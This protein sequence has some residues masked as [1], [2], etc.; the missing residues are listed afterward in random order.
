VY[1][2][3][4]KAFDRVR[5]CLLLNK[6]SANIEPARCLWLRSDFSGRTQRIRIG[7]CVSRDILATSGVPHGNH[8]GPLCF[9]WFVNELTGII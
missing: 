2:D 3:F 9:T 6:M 1:K 8:V 4:S 7:D 5:Q